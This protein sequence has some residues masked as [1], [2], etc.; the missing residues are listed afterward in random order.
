[1]MTRTSRNGCLATANSFCSVA[2][3]QFLLLVTVIFAGTLCHARTHPSVS[4]PTGALPPGSSDQPPD[5]IV[6]TGTCT[7]QPGTYHYHNVN[8]FGGGTLLFADGGP[9]TA[10]DFWAESI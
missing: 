6:D 9:G 7:V 1:M 2:S 8:I 5:L 3:L 4:C 10:T